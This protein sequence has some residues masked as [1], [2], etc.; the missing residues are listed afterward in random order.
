MARRVALLP[1][2]PHEWR[3]GDRT[4]GVVEGADMIV[5]YIQSTDSKTR[6]T[7]FHLGDVAAA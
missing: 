5:G 4:A 7:D 3:E 2:L 1:H 6:N